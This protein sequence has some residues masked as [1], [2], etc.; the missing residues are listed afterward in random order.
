MSGR[1]TFL[2]D[3]RARPRAEAILRH[4]GEGRAARDAFAAMPADDR[5]ALI[6]YLE[7]L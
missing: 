6:R 7:S 4:D 3:G 5:A 1:A 2:H